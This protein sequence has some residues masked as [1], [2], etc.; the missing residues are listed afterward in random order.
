MMQIPLVDLAA[1][2]RPLRGE[3]LRSI[4]DVL[5]SMH[6]FLGPNTRAFEQEFAAYCGAEYAIGV[7]SGTD[8][9]YLALHATGVGQGDE[10]ITTAHTFFAT[11]EA[12]VMAGARPVFVDID[13]ESFTI[14][15]AHVEARV[16]ARTKAII[17]VHLYGQVADMDPILETA[18]RHNLYV[19]ED[20]AQAHG[21]TYKGRRAGSLGHIAGFSFYYSKNL[22]AYGEAG[23]V[24]TSDPQLAERVRIL[25]DHGSEVRYQH[26]QYGWNSR[27]DE[28]QAAVLRVKLRYLETWNEQ[29]IGHAAVYA[30]LLQESGVLLPT[31]LPGRRH[32][33]YVYVVRNPERDQLQRS[34]AE[35]GVSTGIH[36]PV[37]IHL[38]PACRDLGYHEGDLPVTEQ[39]AREVLSLPMYAE[40]SSEQIRYVADSITATRAARMSSIRTPT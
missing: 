39:I 38:Q 37:P 25:R 35:R 9:L 16:T 20:A 31:A 23:A 33:Y 22:G 17:P 34:L 27:L 21:A 28:I 10:V 13:P 8:A 5:E 1:Q 26:L 32:V 7:G 2:F 29:R 14:D 19:I 6:L 11:V 12:I 24:T 18:R 15:P 30:D 40:L 3:I 4:E 36:F